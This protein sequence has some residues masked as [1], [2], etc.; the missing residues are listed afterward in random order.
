MKVGDRVRVKADPNVNSDFWNSCGVVRDVSEPYASVLFGENA[1]VLSY[2]RYANPSRVRTRYLEI[3]SG[4]QQE[5][6]TGTDPCA[7][8]HNI[9]RHAIG[10]NDT[11]HG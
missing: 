10:G 7:A 5:L 6:F 2:G 11:Q 4:Q 9:R 8:R 3:I 1:N